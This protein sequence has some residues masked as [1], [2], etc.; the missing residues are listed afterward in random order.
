MFCERFKGAFG[1]K[2]SGS[3]TTLMNCKNEHYRLGKPDKDYIW[4]GEQTDI[5][6]S[7]TSIPGFVL[8]LA[9]HTESDET[10]K[11]QLRT[12]GLKADI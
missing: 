6:S 4:L 10:Q 5:F 12:P 3:S 8:D 1:G 7:S 9:A 2:E 11:I